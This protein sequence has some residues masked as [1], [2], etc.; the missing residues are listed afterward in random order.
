MSAVNT[1]TNTNMTTLTEAINDDYEYIQ[2]NDRL[3]LIHSIK[4][5]MYQMQS[6]ISSCNSTKKA[7]DWFRLQSANEILD[8]MN[9]VGILS[10][11]KLENNDEN[12]S[13]GNP[14]VEKSWDNRDDLPNGL[15]GYYVHRLLVNYIAMWASPRYAMY[16]AKLLDSHFEHQRDQ[17]L[18]KVEQQRPRM[19]PNGKENSYRYMIWREDSP[20]NQTFTIL[21]M[22]RRNKHSWRAVNKIYKDEAKRFFFRDNLPVAMTPNEDIKYLVKD[23]FEN[24]DARVD[25][26]K[27]FIKKI[28][29]GRLH[30]IITN[31]FKDYQK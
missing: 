24:E 25:G 7:N 5:D 8:E 9:S 29:L 6:I 23:N 13:T 17:L 31:Y 16:I 14:V 30:E 15:R 21:H 2:Y 20:D 27:I 19:V 10:P 3:R 22:I 18:N 12:S 26:S 28:C 11:E 4:D 1:S